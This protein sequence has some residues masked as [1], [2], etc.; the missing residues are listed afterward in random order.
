M[1]ALRRA[2]LLVLCLTLAPFA[3][4]QSNK[5]ELVGLAKQL[6]ASLSPVDGQIQIGRYQRW[7]LTL[8]SAEGKLLSDASVRVQGGM[9][10]HGHGLPTQPQVSSGGT[11]GEYFIEGLRFNMA[12]QWLLLIDVSAPGHRD[13]LRL[14][15]DVAY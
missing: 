9:P 14:A 10:E 7:R 11:P 5:F 13:R 1:G 15:L 8:R 12:G 4:A 3:G 6:Q 2:G